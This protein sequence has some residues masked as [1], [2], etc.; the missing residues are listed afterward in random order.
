MEH[1]KK[2]FR[3]KFNL[4][5]TMLLLW[6]LLNL[7]FDLQTLLIG[8]VIAS[9]V[10]FFSYDTLHDHQGLHFKGI[11]VYRLV[12]YFFVLFLEIFKSSI[13]Y[14]R[15][16]FD[17]TY[18]PVIFRIGLKDL[19]PVKVAIVANSITMTPG[20]ISVE[21]VDQEIYVMVLADPKTSHAEL[22][23]PI[24]ERFERLLRDKE[25]PV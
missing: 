6:V 3:S 2:P 7:R 24:R 18:E 25:N 5:V 12:F 14:I 9:F 4:F 13:F 10:T 15:N 20:T 16:L 23:R 1:R 22:E 11:P 17:K 21:M 19:D 8:T